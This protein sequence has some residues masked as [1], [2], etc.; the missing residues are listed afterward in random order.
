[1][2]KVV[3]TTKVSIY[4]SHRSKMSK[5][6]LNILHMPT[7]IARTI[8]E[9][10]AEF[11]RCPANPEG[12]EFN[13]F[14]CWNHYKTKSACISHMKKC[15]ND[16][17]MEYADDLE[18]EGGGTVYDYHRNHAAKSTTI[19]NYIINND[20]ASLTDLTSNQIIEGIQARL[21]ANGFN[22]EEIY[23]YNTSFLIYKFF[24]VTSNEENSE[25]IRRNTERLLHLI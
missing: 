13:C 1:M 21:I 25:F 10:Q 24:F 5:F 6:Y 20:L 22:S 23:V 2:K 3:N 9:Y 18:I 8:L 15:C 19:K 11:Y 17:G 14:F 16:E 4:N 7:Y 12:F